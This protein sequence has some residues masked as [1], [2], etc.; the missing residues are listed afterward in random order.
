MQAHCNGKLLQLQVGGPLQCRLLLLPIGCLSLRF[1]MCVGGVGITVTN[2]NC[3]LDCVKDDEGDGVWSLAHAHAP[4][5]IRR[6]RSFDLELDHGNIV[7][8]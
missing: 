1:R 2:L 7:D 5:S 4:P 8:Q 3:N 6:R